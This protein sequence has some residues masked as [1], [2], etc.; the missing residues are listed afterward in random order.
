MKLRTN[1]MPGILEAGN[2]VAKI[3]CWKGC[4]PKAGTPKTKKSPTI[5]GKR[6]NNCDC[7]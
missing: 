3:S 4:A 2:S 5:P 1:S 6:V 7:G